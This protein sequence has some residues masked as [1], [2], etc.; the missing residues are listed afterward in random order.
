M[1]RLLVFL[2]WSLLLVGQPALAAQVQVT[3]KDAAGTI[4][5]FTVTTNTDITGN[6]VANQVIC[7]QVAGTTCATVTAGNALKVDGSAVTQPVSLTSTTIT[8]T[9]AATQSG[10]WNVTNISGTVSLPPSALIVGSGGTQVALLGPD[11][12]AQL[13]TVTIGRDQG[14][15]VEIAAGL[16]AQDRVIDNPPDSLQTGDA[17]KV[18]PNAGK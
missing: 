1:N 15:T 13:R 4:R 7:D 14:K 11:G 18:L 9:V 8:G 12:K 16:S 6:L 2:F 3:G 5:N 17:V 10:T